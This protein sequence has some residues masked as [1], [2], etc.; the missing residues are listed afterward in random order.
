[1][2]KATGVRS[3]RT[4]LVPLIDSSVRQKIMARSPQMDMATHSSPRSLATD[5]LPSAFLRAFKS[6]VPEL[7]INQARKVTITM[8]TVRLSRAIESFPKK[9]AA[10]TTVRSMI[11][12]LTSWLYLTILYYFVNSFVDNIDN[13]NFFWDDL[14]Y[15][16]IGRG[17]TMSHRIVSLINYIGLEATV[18]LLLVGSA[19][20]LALMIP[21]GIM[22]TA[23][24]LS[25]H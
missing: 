18:V 7:R 1:M 21:I 10:I 13:D 19:I 24:C 14:I 23:A 20:W 6:L 8:V 15:L 11:M 22:A 12:F 4:R 17:L 25:W 9:S 2:Q 3:I 16:R 5:Q